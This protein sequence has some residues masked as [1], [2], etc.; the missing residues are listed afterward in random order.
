MSS[1]G[2]ISE[3]HPESDDAATYVMRLKHFMVANK[4]EDDKKLPV[5]ITVLGS[6]VI[7]T[8]VDLVIPDELDSKTYDQIIELFLN[9]YKPEK[10]KVEREDKYRV[11]R[12]ARG[13]PTD[14]LDNHLYAVE[15]N[16]KKGDK[17]KSNKVTED[18]LSTLGFVCEMEIEGRKMSL[19][20]DTDAC[21]STLPERIYR[22][23]PQLKRIPVIPTKLSLSTYLGE[24]LEVKGKIYVKVKYKNC[25]YVLPLIVVNTANEKAPILLGRNWLEHIKLDW[26]SIFTV[27]NNIT[28]IL[29]KDLKSKYQDVFEPGT[30]IIKSKQIALHVKEDAV[31]KFCK[32][33]PVPFAIKPLVD[34]E[35]DRLLENKIIKRVKTSEWATPLVVV[36]KPNGNVRLCADYKITLHPVL[37]VEHYPLPTTEELF[38]EL[39]EAKVFTVLDLSHAYLQLPIKEES[40]KLLTINTHMGLFSYTRLL[41]ATGIAAV[42]SHTIEYGQERPI[43]SLLKMVRRDP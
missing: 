42:I 1:T 31:P 6:K 9:Q 43:A 2:K 11:P 29:L 26:Q 5:L 7:N 18:E 30:G 33:R 13:Q 35:I 8:L 41:Y 3:F 20:I 19:Q 16:R 32:H 12:Y 23:V 39:A 14:D 28:E 15:S 37:K 34:K 24:T 27:E 36:L 40:Q 10:L 38:S 21:T 25:E 17:Q 4:I 22:K